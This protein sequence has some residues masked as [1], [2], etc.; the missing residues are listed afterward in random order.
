MKKRISAS[1]NEVLLDRFLDI[2]EH[3][4][5]RSAASIAALLLESGIRLWER[6]HN[7]LCGYPNCRRK[8]CCAR[9]PGQLVEILRWKHDLPGAATDSDVEDLGKP[10]SS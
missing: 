9:T 10:L 7:L 2:C 3:E 4:R 6:N 1:V 8:D 5:N